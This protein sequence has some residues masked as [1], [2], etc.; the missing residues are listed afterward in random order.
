MRTHALIG[1]DILRGSPLLLYGQAITRLED[2]I[3]G[4]G[5]IRH[6]V[7]GDA[8]DSHVRALNPG[9]AIGKLKVNP[10]SDAYSREEVLAFARTP[11]ELQPVAGIVTQ[12]EGNVLSHVQ[13]LAR[14]LGIPNAV[15]GPEPYAKLARHDGKEVLYVVTPGGRVY[16]KDAAEMTEQ[17]RSIYEDYNL[18]TDRASDGS[19]RGA[20]TKL[21]IDHERLSRPGLLRKGRAAT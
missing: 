8:F 12:G 21:D 18:N 14:A 6:Q 10:K 15:T 5:R 4:E 13:L 20:T 3:S 11:S 1:D 9:L 2:H 19:L 7:M 17:D 16:L